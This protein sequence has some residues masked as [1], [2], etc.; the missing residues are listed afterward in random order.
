M[1]DAACAIT[2]TPLPS[3]P[4]R[5]SGLP[6]LRKRKS[7][8]GQARGAW[9]REQTAVAARSRGHQGGCALPSAGIFQGICKKIQCELEIGCKQLMPFTAKQRHP[10]RPFRDRMSAQ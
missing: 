7:R 4:Q 2:T 3:L 5:E 9:G 10:V 8:P 6:D 1:A